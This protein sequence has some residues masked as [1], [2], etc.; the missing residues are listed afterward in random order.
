MYDT[1]LTKEQLE[2]LGFTVFERQLKKRLKVEV[3]LDGPYSSYIGT[4]EGYPSF[5]DII[6]TVVRNVREEENYILR[7]KLTE[8]MVNKY[9]Y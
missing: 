1:P 7:Q 4:I 5:R 9:F 8:E 2:F 3:L 6:T